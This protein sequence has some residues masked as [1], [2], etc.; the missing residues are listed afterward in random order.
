MK[1]KKQK[2]I[3]DKKQFKWKFE[4][5]IDDEESEKKN[6]DNFFPTTEEPKILVNKISEIPKGNMNKIHPVSSSISFK[7]N[8]NSSS[9]PPLSL[10]KLN[11][12]LSR[13]QIGKVT[14]KMINL[15]KQ[16]ILT[17]HP[18]YTNRKKFTLPLRESI[19]VSNLSRSSERKK[20][21]II[22][23]EIEKEVENNRK[24]GEDNT[25]KKE[26]KNVKI[27]ELQYFEV[28]KLINLKMKKNNE[29]IAENNDDLYFQI[30]EKDFQA[31]KISSF[32]WSGAEV[33]FD[34]RQLN[35]YKEKIFIHFLNEKDFV[36]WVKGITGYVIIH[37]FFKL[38]IFFPC[39]VSFSE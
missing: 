29:E 31:K 15:T 33:I 8:I 28:Q 22:E 11:S 1:E 37:L 27:R 39:L 12:S 17:N 26:K 24:K 21:R 19:H 34:L 16:S 10:N 2:Q 35:P 4:Y 32:N 13:F 25:H 20:P 30:K 38:I 6:D 9:S 14:S 23:N 7:R 18:R 5:V 36:I 3:N